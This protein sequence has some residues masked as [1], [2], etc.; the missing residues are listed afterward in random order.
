MTIEYIYHDCF[1]VRTQKAVLVF[2]FWQRP[3][4]W[5]SG[6]PFI[7]GSPLLKSDLD[8]RI[9]IFVSHFHKDH[10]NPEI[11]EW[12]KEIPGITYVISKDVARHA[13]HILRE[14][15]LY[16]GHRPPAES[17]HILKPLENWS[18]DLI[19]VH[20]YD[21]TDTGNA[22]VVETGGKTLM[23]AGDL[24]A[25]I[26]IDEPVE[27]EEAE[28]EIEKKKYL[29]YIWQI[30]RDF[31]EIDAV[32][33]PVDSRIGSEYATGARLLL[34]NIKVGVFLPMHYCLGDTPEELTRLKRDAF[35][36]ERYATDDNPRMI[37]GLSSPGDFIEIK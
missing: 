13:R 26:W 24:N 20:A 19:S 27:E 6:S 14:D 32:M 1:I 2:D 33:F 7:G 5:E 31:P 4:G 8:K 18:D 15:S 12:S 25:W 11:F 28:V 29:R 22:Y 21:S 17:V 35:N 34:M 3:K 9:Y 23:H 30:R 10:Y 16:N 36:Q 37:A